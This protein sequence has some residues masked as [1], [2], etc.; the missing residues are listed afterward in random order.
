MTIA[1]RNRP[2]NTPDAP[3]FT[4]SRRDSN[5]YSVEGHH[6]KAVSC[7]RVRYSH[8]CSCECSE[9]LRTGNCAHCAAVRHHR[10]VA[11][12]GA[13]IAPKPPRKF[14]GRLQAI[15]V[16][17]APRL[18]VESDAE[19]LERTTREHEARQARLRRMVELADEAKVW[20]QIVG[21]DDPR[22][23]AE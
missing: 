4:V 1:D 22:I 14:R 21:P 10:D 7:Y 17:P 6:G 23:A 2:V 15:I 13:D 20:D 12:L 5:T 3:R 16:K 9:Y 19:A 8:G 11:E 18:T